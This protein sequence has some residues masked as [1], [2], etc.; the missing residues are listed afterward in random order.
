MDDQDLIREDMLAE[1]YYGEAG[2]Q[3]GPVSGQELNAKLRG[4]EVA[5]TVL[6]WRQGMEQW[7]PVVA[8]P[9]LIQGVR[10]RPGQVTDPAL[11]RQFKI[12]SNARQNCIA[13]FVVLMLWLA[14]ISV[15][16]HYAMSGKKGAGEPGCIG[17][18]VVLGGIYAAI[19]LPLRWRTIRQLPSPY[20]TLGIIGG[21][22]L[23]VIVC[24]SIIAVAVATVM[25][26]KL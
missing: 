19:Y 2:R 11:R 12:I 3:L 10:I 6:V 18:A 17:T 13:M 25:H 22:G 1:W 26:V 5:P 7:V 16:V 21:V 14:A 4:K 24:L 20:G 9:A 15:Q 8:V 23:I